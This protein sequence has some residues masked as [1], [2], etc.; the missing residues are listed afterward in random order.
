[1]H[2]PTSV[3]TDAD[4]KAPRDMDR[5]EVLIT[6]DEL[7]LGSLAPRVVCPT[8]GAIATFIGT[9]RDHFEGKHVLR[10]E[11]RSLSLSRAPHP[12]FLPR[13]ASMPM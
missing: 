1:M 6:A 10:L 7:P 4:A 2:L 3:R 13:A 8:A 5:D 11:V 12:A 9:T